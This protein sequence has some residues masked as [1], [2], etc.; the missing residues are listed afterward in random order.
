MRNRVAIVLIAA[1]AWFATADAQAEDPSEAPP[2]AEASADVAEDE[3][4][5]PA[6]DDLIPSVRQALYRIGPGDVIAIQVY[7]E[8]S[9]TGEYPVSSSGELDFP[10]IGV[11]GIDGLTTSEVSALLRDRL[12]QGYLNKPHITV[13][14]STYASQ[15]VQVLGAVA[16]PGLYY[17]QGPTTVLQILSI[18]GGVENEGVNEIRV[19]RGGD[20][21]EIIALP[22]ERLLTLGANA[23]PLEAGDVVFVPQS[24]V[25]VMGS[26][27]KPGE[28]TFREG[29]TLSR[30]IAAVGG[31]LPTANLRKVYVLRGDQRIQVNVRR[32]LDG[33]ESDFPLLAGDQVFVNQSVF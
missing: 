26:V 15:P 10:L 21:G 1:W 6:I 28:I 31:A 5:A 14:V 11:I 4:A 19:T 32:I 3:H 12:T 33:K 27:S 20:N 23:T 7:G 8:A 9:L 2:S 22:Y 29:L 24:L 25:S 17:L 18:A 16:K 30:S 13:S